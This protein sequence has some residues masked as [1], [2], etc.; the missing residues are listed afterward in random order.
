MTYCKSIK[1][2]GSN[3]PPGL[4]I[5]EVNIFNITGQKV[6]QTNRTQ[7]IDISQLAVSSYFLKA[8]DTV[9]ATFIRKIIKN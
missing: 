7:N 6:L 5:S 3:I 9:G 1:L 2:P 4:E 8:N